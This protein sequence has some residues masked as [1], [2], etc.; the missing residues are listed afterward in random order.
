MAKRAPPKKKAR[1]GTA[2]PGPPPRAPTRVRA[3]TN[4]GRRALAAREPQIVEDLKQTLLLYGQRVSQTVKV[5]G[6]GRGR[7]EWG[8]RRGPPPLA[9]RASR[10]LHGHRTS[11]AIFIS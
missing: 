4:A 7:P 10:P 11:W 3:T 8:P 6:G 5:R 2:G 1:K 9:P